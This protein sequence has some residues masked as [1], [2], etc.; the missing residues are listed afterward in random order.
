MRD[1]NDYR[2]L[3]ALA[4]A[5]ALDD[6]EQRELQHHA[7]T[8]A[9]CAAELDRWAALAGALRRLPTPQPS[10]LVVERARARAEA[11]LTTASA[12]GWNRGMVVFAILFSWT[13]TLATWPVVRVLSE[14]MLGWLNLQQTW[15]G[16]AGYTALA[17][18][19]AGIAAILLRLRERQARMQSHV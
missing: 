8:C 10:P 5:G 9:E 3:L 17:W 6:D 11:E 19:T 12:E 4:A 16:L 13:L 14:G 1:H 18:V 7:T 15:L 2:E